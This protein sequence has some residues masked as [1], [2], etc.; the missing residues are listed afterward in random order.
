MGIALDT[1]AVTAIIFGEPE[2]EATRSVTPAN[3]KRRR[4]QR[5]D[6]S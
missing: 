2:V 3:T 5:G 1:S 4:D 6:A